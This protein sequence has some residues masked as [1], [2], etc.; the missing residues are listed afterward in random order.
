MSDRLDRELRKRGLVHH[1]VGHGWT[2]EVLGY[3]SKYG[4]ES[5][6]TLPD[7]KKPLVA[8]LAGKRELYATAPILTSLC[9][10][11]PEVGDRMVELIVDYAK[12]RP[13]VDYLHVWLSDARNN[14]CECENC[15]QD[16]PADQY[17]RILNQLDEA[18]TKEGI[19]T[20]ICFLLYHELLFAPEKEMLQNPVLS[21]TDCALATF[22]LS[23]HGLNSSPKISVRKSPITSEAR[24]CI[25]PVVWV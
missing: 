22:A 25:S 11:N 5:G 19:P 18:L 6:L 8:E 3:S 7:E 1:R 23:S 24:F 12:Q 15:R 9:F 14:I 4:W 16:L 17:V 21:Q 10:S 20:K 2:G 13:D